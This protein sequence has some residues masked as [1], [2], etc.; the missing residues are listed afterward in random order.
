MKIPR[1]KICLYTPVVCGDNSMKTT[2]R[3]AARLGVGGVELMN[4]CD[5]LRTPDM[6]A[7]RQLAD[8]ARGYGL[9]IPC[10]SVAVDILSDPDVAVAKVKAF[11]DICSAL[12]IPLLHH[13][14]ASDFRCYDIDDAERER[15]F[16]FCAEFALSLADY[17][18]S[19]GV[20]TVIEDQGFVFNG[21]KN[22]DRLCTLSGEKIGIVAD[23]GNIMFFDQKP[24]DFIRAM[25][26]RVAH[27]HLKDY[28]LSKTPSDKC[29]TTRLSN[30]LTDVM[31]GE[32]NADFSDVMQAFAEI[33]YDGM[34]S[35]EY[36]RSVNC[37]VEKII[38]YLQEM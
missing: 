26:D 31:I 36:S 27:A 29:Y 37:D 11:A 10:F 13:T 8:M 17:A 3:E 28:R 12:E 6:E 24:S 32:G 14:V 2:I 35:L 18:T 5:E 9:A 25:G 15:R 33:G 23:T 38:E 4:F 1:E 19:R 16:G 22:C 7:A 30:F 20:R 34:Y 21:V